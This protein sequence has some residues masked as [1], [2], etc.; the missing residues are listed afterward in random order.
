M[1][2][3]SSPS[4]IFALGAALNLPPS[5]FPFAAIP[6]VI[7]VEIFLLPSMMILHWLLS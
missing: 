5:Y 1:I 2:K 6:I 7:S 3:S 4:D